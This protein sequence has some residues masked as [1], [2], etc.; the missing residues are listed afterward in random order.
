MT[1]AALNFFLPLSKWTAQLVNRFN[2]HTCIYLQ[3][4]LYII[5]AMNVVYIFGIRRLYSIY[6]QS[7]QLYF[8]DFYPLTLIGASP[9]GDS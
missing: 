8:G 9:C 3:S 6:W 5:Y 1:C 7:L 4:L 2:F